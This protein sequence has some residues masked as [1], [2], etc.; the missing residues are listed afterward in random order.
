MHSTLKL[1]DSDPHDDFAIAPDAVRAPYTVEIIADDGGVLDTFFQN[2]RYYVRGA[3]NRAYT[4][5]E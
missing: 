1:R 4:V 2:G 5:R 3:T